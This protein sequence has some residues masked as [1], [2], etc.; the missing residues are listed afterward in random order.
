MKDR[1]IDSRLRTPVKVDAGAVWTRRPEKDSTAKT[2]ERELIFDFDMNDYDDV[3]TCCTGKKVCVKCWQLLV[4]A[5]EI[6]EQALAED[7]DYHKLLFVFS[8]GRGL[9]IWVCDKKARKLQDFVRKGVVDYLELVTGNDKAASLLGENVIGKVED[10][11][12]WKHKI[13]DTSRREVREFYLENYVSEPVRRALEILSKH[14]IKI[15]DEQAIF[16]VDEK[17]EFIHG[18]C[19]EIMLRVVAHRSKEMRERVSDRWRRGRGQSARD[20]LALV[21]AEVAR[22]EKSLTLEDYNAERPPGERVQRLAFI[23]EEIML[24]FLYP[25]M[26]YNVSTMQNHLLKLPFS[27]HP[28]SR[29]ISIP[30][31]RKEVTTFNP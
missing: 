6:L 18:K 27:V 30:L 28:K 7:F 5:V 8:G 31:S 24:S 13:D 23:E 12:L 3:R 2:V 4:V 14:F 26:D 10:S 22:Y 21:D 20:M 11:H 16:A 25:R 1:M 15:L 29:K 17:G 19:L 9:H